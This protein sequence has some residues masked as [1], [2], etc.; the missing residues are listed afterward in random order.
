[1]GGA[2][3]APARPARGTSGCRLLSFARGRPAPSRFLPVAHPESRAG[4]A[5]G[6]TRPTRGAL[7][8]PRPR[9]PVSSLAPGRVWPP[10]ARE[11][12]EACLQRAGGSRIKEP[13]A[14]RPQL[15][16]P[17]RAGTGA[18]LQARAVE[19]ALRSGC[20]MLGLSAAAARAICWSSRTAKRSCHTAAWAGSQG[21]LSL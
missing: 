17:P 19:R 10:R 1:M 8:A 2:R 21:C 4:D 18:P 11:G 5:L 9:A 7:P 3:C 20:P 14:R 16:S 12:K 6:W 13:A 15:H